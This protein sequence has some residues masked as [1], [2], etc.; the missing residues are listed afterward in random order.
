[1]RRDFASLEE[2]RN[3]ALSLLA[4]REHG[5]L[6]L[7]RKLAQRGAAA[8]W[9]EQSLNALQESGLLS[10]SR[11]LQSF[12]RMRANAGFGPL[13]IRHDLAARGLE[14]S[15]IES[16]L[17]TD[18]LNWPCLLAALWQKKFKGKRPQSAAEHAKQARF[19]AQR[20]WPPAL[21]NPLLRG[22]AMDDW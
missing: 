2:V 6:E 17:Q 15:A 4:R 13:H 10:E 8:D 5:R 18:E 20:G 3:A 12:I 11:Y 9:I 21:I 1:M 14:R 7:A 16:A 19:L 22:A